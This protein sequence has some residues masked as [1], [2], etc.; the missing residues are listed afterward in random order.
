MAFRIQK[1]IYERRYCVVI[2]DNNY[3]AGPRRGRCALYHD[4]SD[5]AR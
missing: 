3:H 5:G 2:L 1:L 4:T